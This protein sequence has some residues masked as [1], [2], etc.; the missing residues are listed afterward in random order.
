LVLITGCYLVITGTTF[1]LGLLPAVITLGAG[2]VRAC[3]L[4][5]LIHTGQHVSIH[6][7]GLFSPV[8]EAGIQ[9]MH[10]CARVAAADYVGTL[11]AVIGHV[12]IAVH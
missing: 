7:L 10:L 5:G 8:I 3:G 1:R 9:A 6:L 4:A 12:V 11:A 2:R